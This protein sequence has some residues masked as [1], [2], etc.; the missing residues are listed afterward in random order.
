MLIRGHSRRAGSWSICWSGKANYRTRAR[1]EEAVTRNPNNLAALELLANVKP[2]EGDKQS[3][4]ATFVRI[5]ELHPKSPAVHVARAQAERATGMTREAEA[6]LR[7]ALELQKTYAPAQAMLFELLVQ[8]NRLSQAI[9]FA[10]QLKSDFPRSPLGYVFEAEAAVF[11]KKYKDAIP[12]YRKALEL[13]RAPDFAVRLYL[14][15]TL[16]GEGKEA[17]ADLKRWVTD[18]PGHID[19][20]MQL[21]R[22]LVDQGDYGGAVK[23]FQIV[24]GLTPSNP[25][26]ANSIAWAYYKTGNLTQA[27]RFAEGAHKLAPDNP[28][29]SDTL[30]G[31]LL[32]QGK[33]KEA[34]ELLAKAATVLKDSPEVRY[35]YGAALARS[36]DKAR[37]VQELKSA[38]ALN[39][40][41]PER[42]GAVALLAKLKR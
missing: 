8:Q 34:L 42:D 36:G 15:R 6:S 27:M 33:N 21:G 16:A 40:S 31:L 10:E 26:A 11:Q 9:E 38:L 28:Y 12:P 24:L 22:V 1:A 17:L 3:A 2:R 29:I 32:Q 4:V 37:A 13:G 14:V 20:R 39:K 5:A 41:F 25:L 19:T 18:H 35:H 23:E 7:R 30:G